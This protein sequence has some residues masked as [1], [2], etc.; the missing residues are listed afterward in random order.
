[1]KTYVDPFAEL[2]HFCADGR[3]VGL[4]CDLLRRFTFLDSPERTK[5]WLNMAS[6]IAQVWRLPAQNTQVVAMTLSDDADS[7]QWVV[8]MLK[9]PF[10][11]LSYNAKLLNNVNAA[12]RNIR[13]HSNVVLV[14]EFVGSGR[15]VL[16]RIRGLRE[17]F[18][19]AVDEGNYR[20]DICVLAGMSDAR[21]RIEDQGIRI[22][23]AH[24]L[25]KGISDHY[26]GESL[27]AER[28]RMLNMESRLEY[29]PGSKYFP[30]GY[31]QAEALY[32]TEE[33]NAVNNMFPV[34]WWK[35]LK[36]RIRRRTM[37]VRKED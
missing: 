34:F 35:Y 31:G 25:L 2:I 11:E 8:Q 20:V 26:E 7:G 30:F 9:K 27:E 22:H 6:Q 13:T 16:A 12:R 36:G 5:G 1:M 10:A 21:K 37:F 15:T 3:E 28:A 14:D 29:P 17:T 23:A 18:D 33:G 24:W 32:A 19:E 4:I